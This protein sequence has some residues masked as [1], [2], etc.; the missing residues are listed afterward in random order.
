[1]NIEG[2]VITASNGMVFVDINDN[3]VGNKLSLGCNDTA[4]NYREMSFAEAEEL[5]VDEEAENGIQ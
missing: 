3:I 4:N 5:A 1:M 2:N